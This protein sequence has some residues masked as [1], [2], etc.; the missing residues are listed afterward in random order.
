MIIT[1]YV[2]KFD[3]IGGFVVIP[4]YRIIPDKNVS[5]TGR[6]KEVDG[7]IYV[8]ICE[9]H[10]FGFIKKYRYIH[11]NDFTFTDIAYHDCNIKE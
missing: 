11:E 4:E 10:F 2:Y 7:D 8:E 5:I 9:K 3:Y 6:Y 1:K